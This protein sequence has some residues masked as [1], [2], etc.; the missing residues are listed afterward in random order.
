MSKNMFLFFGIILTLFSCSSPLHVEEPRKHI[1]FWGDSMTA[2]NGGNGVTMPN[3]VKNELKR[4]IFNGG[5]G[6]LASTN[7]ACL[8]GGLEFI[9][10]LKGNQIKNEGADTLTYYNIL[11]YIHT[12]SQT[13]LVSINGIK[14][15]LNR[16]G[17]ITNPIVSDYFY[18]ERTS[19]GEDIK[20]PPNGIKM[21]FDDAV[22]NRSHLSIIWSGRNDPRDDAQIPITVA[23]I[24]SMI[25]YIDNKNKQYLVISVC[26]GSRIT[27]G[28]GSEI[29][30]NIIS[31]NNKLQSHFGDNYIDLR[32]YMVERA[33]YDAKISPT[34][35][36]LE[37]IASD[38]IP[39]SLLYDD[40]HFN[41]IGYRM[42]GIYISKIIRDR[43]W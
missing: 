16:V 20:I 21:V 31:L 13:R 17:N 15:T 7:I 14:G 32:K 12:T 1:A 25:N 35:E 8:Q 19:I 4:E 27:E 18:F 40:V 38:C 33:I 43:N 23:N 10:K 39:K 28:C 41:E 30:A 42:A 6:G 24:E 37:D 36:D 11:P 3:I 22:N 9:I 29:Y 34:S 26:N 5:V 2:G